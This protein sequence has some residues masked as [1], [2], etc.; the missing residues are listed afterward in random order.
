[1]PKEPA[2]L[3]LVEIAR[4]AKACLK[5]RDLARRRALLREGTLVLDDYDLTSRCPVLVLAHL[6]DPSLAWARY[7]NDEVFLR[8]LVRQGVLATLKRA[9]GRRVKIEVPVELELPLEKPLQLPRQ[10]FHGDPVEVDKVVVV[11]S[12]DAWLPHEREI[13]L[14]YYRGADT[15]DPASLHLDRAVLL[16][17]LALENGYDIER[18]RILYF[19]GF[20]ELAG[21]YVVD[22]RLHRSIQAREIARRALEERVRDLVN[23]KP[24]PLYQKQCESCVLNPKASRVNQ[25][26]AYGC[27]RQGSPAVEPDNFYKKAGVNKHRDVSRDRTLKL[28]IT[29]LAEAKAAGNRPR[30]LITRRGKYARV[31]AYPSALAGC[32]LKFWYFVYASSI[33]G[34][35]SQ[36]S[37]SAIR[38][39]IVHNG[40]QTLIMEAARRCPQLLAGHGL[41]HVSVEEPVENA[42]RRG[43][44]VYHVSGRVD[45]LARTRDGRI[46]VYEVKTC[47]EEEDCG[48]A[49]KH[50]AQQARIYRD[51]LSGEY[52]DDVETHLYYV[53]LGPGKDGKARVSGE[54]LALGESELSEAKSVDELID[55]VHRVGFNAD[56]P[57]APRYK[58]ECR[59]CEYRGLCQAHS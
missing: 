59:F 13:L 44:V 39:T 57:T 54:D 17:L 49:K 15:G 50:H 3:D 37:F 5:E 45:L 30:P 35:G 27:P 20:K 16:H 8:S 58:W 26:R 48:E 36:L 43:P 6:A 24:A 29:I 12:L 18:V 56:E 33:L 46:L 52:G 21:E 1:L 9:Q 4:R 19:A 55:E 22:T 23:L 10:I 51:I 25:G 42:Y 28:T 38:G 40:L 2:S 14:V 32:P 41:D 47:W 53:Y 11:G 34:G 31:T 7:D